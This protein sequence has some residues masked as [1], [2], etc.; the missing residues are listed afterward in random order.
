MDL[1]LTDPPY[2]VSYV[3]KTADALTIANDGTDETDLR[4]LLSQA[5]AVADPYLRVG[6][7][8]YIWYASKQTAAFWA[9]VQSVH[10]EVRQQLIWAKN[11]FVL[12]R[13]DYHWQHEPCLYGWKDGAA[14]D[15]HGGRAQSTILQHDKPQTSK[16]HPTMK[17]IALFHQLICNSSAKGGAVY[18]P[19]CGSGTTLLACEQAGRRCFAAE[20]S[21]RF[22]DVILERWEQQTGKQAVCIHGG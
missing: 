15:W 14:H 2:G 4:L 12:G 16:E 20:V 17:P 6:G 1:L 10:W 18:D 8:F 5:F 19:F 11:S 13:Q 21:P 9:A 3:G 22:C 7:S